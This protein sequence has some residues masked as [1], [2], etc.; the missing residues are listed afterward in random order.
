MHEVEQPNR[1]EPVDE[2]PVEARQVLLIRGRSC[3]RGVRRG[4]GGGVLAVLEHF[5]EGLGGRR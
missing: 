1:V 5:G 2:R 3:G 4:G